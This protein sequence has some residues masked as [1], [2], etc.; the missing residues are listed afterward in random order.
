MNSC[1]EMQLK[2]FFF[3]SRKLEFSLKWH[4]VSLTKIEMGKRK[5]N[6]SLSFDGHLTVAKRKIGF[7]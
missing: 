6:H 4:K 7:E 5:T 3:V 1:E 2:L